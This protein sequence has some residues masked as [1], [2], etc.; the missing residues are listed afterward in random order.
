MKRI[1]WPWAAAAAVGFAALVIAGELALRARYRHNALSPAP[2][3]PATETVTIVALGDSIA[4]GAPGLPEDAWPVLLE[5]RLQAVYPGVRW[6]IHNAGVPGDT[7]PKGYARFERD[8][9]ATHPQMVLIAFGLN[10]CYPA[11]YGMDRWLEEAVPTGLR[12][13]YVWRA[14]SVRATRAGWALGVTGQ[15]APESTPTAA[16]RTSPLGFTDALQALVD[17]VRMLDARP[18]LLTMTPL[19]DS[20]A[21][22]VVWRAATY[23]P[24]NAAIRRVAVRNSVPLVELA[25]GAPPDALVPDGFHLTV[26]GQAWV[27]EQVFRQLEAAGAWRGLSEDG[28]P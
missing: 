17:R 1:L 26:A 16:P 12:R 23:E 18:V 7:A 6:R 8:V 11:R 14:V 27:A 10:D 9:A 25:T 3:T 20:D 21:V 2:A 22:G 24:Y 28:V 5:Q 13:S 19:A 15:P 4:F